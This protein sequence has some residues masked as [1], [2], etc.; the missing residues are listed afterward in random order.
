MGSELSEKP[1]KALVDNH[2]RRSSTHDD[3][4][5][6]T[7]SPPSAG[8]EKSAAQTDANLS[9]LDSKVVVAPKEMDNDPFRH[10]PEHEATILRKRKCSLI[11]HYSF[12]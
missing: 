4:T 11:F 2:D 7:V 5:A 10:L 6:S 12:Y 1:E 9:K 3:S 8:G